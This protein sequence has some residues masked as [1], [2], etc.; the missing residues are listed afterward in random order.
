[1]PSA[2]A[3]AP[4]SGAVFADGDGVAVLPRVGLADARAVGREQPDPAGAGAVVRP[5]EAGAARRSAVEGDDRR[6]VGVAV[7]VVADEPAV[8]GA[9]GSWFGCLRDVQHR[10]PI[11]PCARIP[12]NS[13]QG[14]GPWRQFH[15]QQLAG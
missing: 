10:R 2:S 4:S 14:S 13:W 5:R 15:H 12:T 9:D 6:A 3:K 7:V 11:M 8:R 1:M